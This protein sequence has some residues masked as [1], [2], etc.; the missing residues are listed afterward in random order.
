MLRGLKIPVRVSPYGSAEVLEGPSVVAQ[1]II[2]AIMPSSNRNPWN[3][4]LAPEETLTFEIAD[5]QSIGGVFVGHIRKVFEIMERRGYAKLLPGSRGISN[6]RI[7]AETFVF[8]RYVNLEKDKVEAI[9]FP[10]R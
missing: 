5:E 3:Q 6:S 1:N 8:V 10:V 7:G 9:R 2:L 4:E